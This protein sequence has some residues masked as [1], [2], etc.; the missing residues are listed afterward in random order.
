MAMDPVWLA[1]RLKQVV[2]SITLVN[3]VAKTQDTTV[4][5]GERWIL[6]SIKVTNID[7]VIRS[8]EIDK[9][10]EAA[11][12]SRIKKYCKS[13][14]AASG[15][16]QWPKDSP[17]SGDEQHWPSAPAEILD[18]GNTISVVWSAGGASAGGTDADGLV[19]EYLRFPI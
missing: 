5:T 13:N 1:G 12:T 10:K 15:T 19:I 6:L 17:I 14:I 11:K 9:W 4:P 16:M 18:P 7:D 3:N 8:T 2:T